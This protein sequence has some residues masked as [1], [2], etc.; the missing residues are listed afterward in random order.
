MENVPG[1]EISSMPGPPPRLHKHERRYTPGTYSV[2]PTSRMW[3]DDYGGLMTFGD[4][5]GLKFPDICLIGEEKPR[6]N[7]TQET[8]PDRGSKRDPLRD[9]RAC[10]RLFHSDGLY[11]ISV[12]KNNYNIVWVWFITLPYNRWQLFIISGKYDVTRYIQLNL[13]FSY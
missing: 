5:V 3:N 11:D 7:L 2:I 1:W 12:W 9:K 10:Y 13:H 4:L 8:C 6:K